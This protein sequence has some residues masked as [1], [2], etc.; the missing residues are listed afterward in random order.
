MKFLD[1]NHTI[2]IADK[3]VTLV[4]KDKAMYIDKYIAYKDFSFYWI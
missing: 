4:I 3:E 2:L 1:D